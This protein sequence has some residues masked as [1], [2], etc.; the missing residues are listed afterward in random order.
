MLNPPS[1]F[2]RIP[3]D[4]LY[5]L[6][7]D[8]KFDQFNLLSK[9]SY[10]EI[11]LTTISELI[12]KYENFQ[13]VRIDANMYPFFLKQLAIL[14]IFYY[15]D[16]GLGKKYATE[17]MSHPN[18]T[19]EQEASA[20]LL[21]LEASL[22][23]PQA[24][25]KSLVS[26][27]NSDK[28]SKEEKFR[29]VLIK[30]ELYYREI[31]LAI[32]AHNKELEMT[33]IEE[34]KE[35]LLRNAFE[36]SYS[37]NADS[38]SYYILMFCYFELFSK[39]KIISN[40]TRIEA[41]ENSIRAV[42]DQLD[43]MK[44]HPYCT[45]ELE[46]KLDMLRFQYSL[47]GRLELA[48]KYKSSILRSIRQCGILFSSLACELIYREMIEQ[49]NENNQ[50]SYALDMINALLQRECS[51]SFALWLQREKCY[52][53]LS[54]NIRAEVQCDIFPF[55]IDNL[56]M[57]IGTLENTPDY[58]QDILMFEANK[59]LQFYFKNLPNS[60]EQKAK[61]ALKIVLLMEK[62]NTAQVT[63][64]MKLWKAQIYFDLFHL[65]SKPLYLA[66]YQLES[67]KIT[68]PLNIKILSDHTT[69]YKVENRGYSI[70]NLPI[71]F[72]L[73]TEPTKREAAS[74]SH[75]TIYRD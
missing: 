21:V 44:Q 70:I 22:L 58:Y 14:Q 59:S 73:P 6:Y 42:S 54:E 32:K 56:D 7:P 2:L 60:D 39:V 26:D 46:V 37:L 13:D 74:S 17:L 27:I 49:F 62:L 31:K 35:Y 15:K 1:N 43:E 5:S 36:E 41:I 19:E 63:D 9:I 20:R 33:L 45:N 55:S 65:T 28:L 40:S 29:F 3:E 51:K 53:E 8:L 10:E 61:L 34:M 64:E 47:N 48:L 30:G 69:S 71:L 23:N 57:I 66:S 52:T 50:F 18:R 68:D 24:L 75:F 12:E 38:E 72:S 25:P 67:K 11:N 16:E 4:L